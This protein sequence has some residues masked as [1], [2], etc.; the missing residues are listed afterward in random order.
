MQA[1]EN[2]C[3]LKSRNNCIMRRKIVDIYKALR[4]FNV[5]AG[6]VRDIA[7][8]Y[9]YWIAHPFESRPPFNT[10][11]FMDG[12]LYSMPYLDGLLK[13][14]FVGIEIEGIVYLNQYLNNVRQDLLETSIK[15]IKCRLAKEFDALSQFKLRLP[16]RYEAKVLA[17]RRKVTRNWMELFSTSLVMCGLRLILTI[18]KGLLQQSENVVPVRISRLRIQGQPCI[19]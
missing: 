14:Q 9:R 4:H 18:R 17:E 16:T 15:T 13:D 10:V 19:W 12:K 6:E 5:T 7:E 11:Y 3:S 1:G 2:L 8:G